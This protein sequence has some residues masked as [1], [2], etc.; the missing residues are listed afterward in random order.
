MS[1][2]KKDDILN[3]E[4]A[5]LELENR[6]S[7]KI[8][9]FTETDEELNALVNG[10]K[11]EY[12]DV[13]VRGR[14]LRFGAYSVAIIAGFVAII[15]AVN[16]LFGLL[17]DRISLKSDL[18]ADNKYTISDENK[19]FIKSIESKVAITVFCTR[20]QY[21]GSEFAYYQSRAGIYDPSEGDYYKQAIILLDEYTKLNSNISLKFI[22]LNK[23][24]AETLAT[25]YQSQG[26]SIGSF[27]IEGSNLSGT[28]RDELLPFDKLYTLETDQMY[29]YSQ[30]TGSTVESAVTAAIFRTI[31]DKTVKVA[32]YTGNGCTSDLSQLTSTLETL[33]YEISTFD[34]LTLGDIPEG[35][36]LMIMA[37]P[38]IDISEDIARKLGDFLDN[39]GEKNKNLLYFAKPGAVLPNLNAFMEQWNIKQKDGTLYET[40]SQAIYKSDPTYIYSIPAAND[41]FD[42]FLSKVNITES[43]SMVIAK[44]VAVLEASTEVSSTGVIKILTALPSTVVRPSDADNSWKAPTPADDAEAPVT[45]LLATRTVTSYEAGTVPGESHIIAFASIDMLSAEYESDPAIISDQIVYSIVDTIVNVNSVSFSIPAKTIENPT[46]LPSESSSDLMFYLFM[47]IMPLAILGAG[48]GIWLR[49]QHS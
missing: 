48:I 14:G 37:A 2:N 13:R 21:I 41:T 30:L 25:K 24:E 47:I 45:A 26:I 3:Q 28:V 20:E 39:K 49:R 35:T 46:F 9:E 22:D 32:V 36:D 40:N 44:G 17:A 8:E 15:I 6:A 23:P 43:D 1:K 27:I 4:P 7:E 29:G 19:D 16:V 31:S 11:A 33:N 34:N 18:T 42:K 38:T 5:E 10:K 12:S